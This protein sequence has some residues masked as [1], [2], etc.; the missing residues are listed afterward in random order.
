VDGAIAESLETWRA[1]DALVREAE[2]LAGEAA[3]LEAGD[4]AAPIAGARAQA[5]EAEGLERA[6]ADSAA[7]ARTRAAE[8]R[9]R[10]DTLRG[11][12]GDAFLLD[13]PDQTTHASAV[14]TLLD[15]ALDARAEIERV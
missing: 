12:L 1:A 14:R 5:A 15:A 10:I 4:P 13:A 2:R 3:L 7:A 6:H 9:P 8:L 11:L